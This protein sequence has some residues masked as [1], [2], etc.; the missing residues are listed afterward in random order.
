MQNRFLTR[1]SLSMAKIKTADII[2]TQSQ[3]HLAARR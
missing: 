1:S 3:Q 2:V